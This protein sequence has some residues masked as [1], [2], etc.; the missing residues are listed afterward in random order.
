VVKTKIEN[1]ETGL[2][3]ARLKRPFIT[4]LRTALE[5]ENIIVK[6]TTDS[7]ITGYGEAA[8]TP[9][10]TGETKG[11]IIE[12]IE[13]YIKPGILGMDIEYFED[14]IK[15]IHGS[16]LYN[17][18][19]KAACDIALY[20]ILAKYYKVPLYRLLGGTKKSI[21]T[22]ITISLSDVDT[23]VKNSLAAVGEGFNILKIK[24]GEGY[25]KDV[26]RVKAIREAVG[27]NITLRLD[28]NQGWQPKEAIAAI[29]KLAEYDIE[30]V[31]Q[32]VKAYDLEGLKEVTQN[33]PVPIMVDE[34]LFSPFDAFKI[35]SMK[36][37]NII[38]IKL[39]KSGGIYN[40]LKIN[41]IA[42][43]EGI[44][45]MIGSMME[46][47]ISVTA[48]AHL[49]AAKSNITRYDLDAP[50]LL[51]TN[52]VRGGILYRGSEISFSESPG[53]GIDGF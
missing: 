9:A 45:C 23:M 11:S 50:Y 39:M 4:A 42:E 6:I 16:I 1:L 34:G 37:A 15:S 44:E 51:G 28:A 46:S 32:P 30:L 2:I 43:S 5:I 21:E 53:L 14:I 13:K 29:T 52:S 40:A 41:E 47:K 38:N 27:K 26:E 19:A 22:D 35:I 36:A 48:A 10:I 20:D 3:K 31:E 17:N 49:A 24:V 18:S 7:G 8:P 12:A 25:K 33:V